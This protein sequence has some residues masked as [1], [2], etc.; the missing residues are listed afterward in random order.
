MRGKVV[1]IIEFSR[2]R[3]DTAFL[4]YTIKA[5]GE[6]LIVNLSAPIQVCNDR[7]ENRKKI[8]ENKL[9]GGIHSDIFDEDPDLHYVPASVMRNFYA[10]DSEE[11]I[12]R[13][14]EQKLVLSLLPT[15]GYFNIDNSEDDKD[16]FRANTRDIVETEIF[17]LLESE[18]SY[19]DYYYRR[20][21]Q[22]ENNLGVK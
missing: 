17:S 4:Y 2:P 19:E 9:K 15:R 1:K 13:A 22:L 11:G 16:S 6:C 7:N 12:K 5:L 10:K 18:E 14:R 8:L 21:K 20:L 3:Y